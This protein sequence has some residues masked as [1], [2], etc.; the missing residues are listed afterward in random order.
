MTL[1]R[2]NS[3][4]DL[5]APILDPLAHVTNDG[6]VI[7]LHKTKSRFLCLFQSYEQCYFKLS[8]SS[9]ALS[10]SPSAVPLTEKVRPILP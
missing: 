8:A 2:D 3:S 4:G 5:P 10:C 6:K 7:K 9:A 1:T